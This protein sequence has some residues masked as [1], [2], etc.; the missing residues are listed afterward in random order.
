MCFKD[1][2]Y[3]GMLNERIQEREIEEGERKPAH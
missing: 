3:K 1:E 2:R